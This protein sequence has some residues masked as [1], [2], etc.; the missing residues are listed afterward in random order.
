MRRIGRRVR[1]RLLLPPITINQLQGG[2]QSQGGNQP[3]GGYQSQGR[4]Q[5][6][7]GNQL[8][9]GSQLQDANNSPSH[10]FR[11]TPY[12]KRARRMKRR[13]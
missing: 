10:M 9:S 7:G 12:R 2:N 4:S 11:Y 3:Q 6:Q 8:Q 13:Q 5:S 1:R